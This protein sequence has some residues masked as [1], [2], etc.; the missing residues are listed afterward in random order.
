MNLLGHNRIVGMSLLILLFVYGVSNAHSDQLHSL[1][2]KTIDDENKPIN[3]E[4]V[5][6]WFFDEPDKKY[7]LQC[8]QKNC[9]QWLIRNNKPLVITIYALASKVK[10]NDPYCW[11]WFEGKAQNQIDQKELT[12]TLSY[13]ST[14]CK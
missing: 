3:A 7:T 4:I 10:K 2:V 8:K 12:I 11:E 9:S 6:W 14:V 13:T 5:N 1:L